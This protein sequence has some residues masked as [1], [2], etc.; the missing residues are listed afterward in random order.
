MFDHDFKPERSKVT[1]GNEE[2]GVIPSDFEPF[3]P[4]PKYSWT[5]RKLPSHN[6][7][8]HMVP[9]VAPPI[10]SLPQIIQDI[11]ERTWKF[12][13]PAKGASRVGYDG[14]LVTMGTR[15]Q[16]SRGTVGDTYHSQVRPVNQAIFTKSPNPAA[17]A[18]D[19]KMFDQIK[20]INVVSFRGDSRPP[21]VVIGDMGGFTPPNSRTDRYYLENN[22]H[23]AFDNYLQRR[24][25]RNVAKDVFLRAVDASAPSPE[26][27]RLLIDYLMWR[28]ITE[29]EAVN[30]GRM[31]ENECL[32]GY[33]STSRAI[34]SSLTFATRYGKVDGWVYVTVVHGGFIIPFATL[35]TMVDWG[36]SEAEIAQW[37]PI[38]SSRIV[39]FVGVSKAKVPQTPI[40][41]RRSFRKTENVAFKYMFNVMSGMTPATA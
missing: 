2:L 26:Q 23:A 1:L 18:A 14:K 17:I 28:K 39:G 22:I 13:E 6:D 27:K 41:F 7:W 37:G 24:Y 16:G 38:P 19:W 9:K 12:A 11:L 30:L 33:T 35:K 34:D 3:E 20:R 5:N 8:T 36:S 31:V 25:N 32:K 15:N 40:F 29:G 10:G 21:R 4:N